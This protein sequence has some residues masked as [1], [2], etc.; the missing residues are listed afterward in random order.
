[1]RARFALL[2]P[3]AGLAACSEDFQHRPDGPATAPAVVP[4]DAT[5]PE[6]A[7]VAKPVTVVTPKLTAG[8]GAGLPLARP[9]AAKAEAYDQTTKEEKAAAVAP[10]K[11]GEQKLGSTVASLGNPTEQGFWIKTP[12]VKAPAKGRLAVPA[13]G[14]SVNVD[15]L[16]L[17]GGAS[18]GSQVS[19]AALQM[20]GVSLTG[21]PRLDVFRQ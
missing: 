1:M 16:P 14:K 17:A 11:A 20:L 18:G 8:G 9:A 19:L 4:V 7:P 15:L 2:L 10:V 13:T 3:L 5:L 21:L 6:G 12:L